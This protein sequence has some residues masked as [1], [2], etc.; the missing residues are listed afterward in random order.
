MKRIFGLTLVFILFACQPQNAGII[1]NILDGDNIISLQTDSN[2]PA[3]ILV[4]A[5]VVLS[6]VDKIQ[7]HGADLPADFSLPPGGAYTLQIRRANTLTLITPD[8]HLT[9][10]TAAAN[11]GQA[12]AQTGLKLF[13]AD[14]VAPALETPVN[15][16]F[17][18]TYRPARDLTVSTDGKTIA[19][20]SSQQTIGQALASAGFA[21][22]GLD[23]SL[24]GE[25][26]PLPPDGQIKIM[27][28]SETV[29]LQEKAIPFSKKYEYSVD[30]PVGEQKVLQV[31]ELGLTISRIRIRYEDGAEVGRI[32]EAEIVVL[33][34]RESIISLSTQIQI[35]TLNTP[36]GQIQYW[37]AVQMYTT[38]Y[39]PCGSGTPKCSYGTASGLPVKHGVVALIPSLY[40]QLAGSQVYIPGYGVGVIGDV[41]G[42]FP[43]GRL[44]IDLGYSDGDY[45]NWSGFH[46]VYFLAPAPVRIPAGLN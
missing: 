7:F 46:T 30:Q 8:G 31:G 29:T 39:S 18:V 2:I 37:R 35:Q 16:D 34:P 15:T 33:Q 40:N 44:W 32:T 6:A 4:Q 3:A 42:G 21:L 12:L 23:K 19:L 38:S 24:P 5:G 41:G 9:I 25:S 14:F 43:D 28:I 45:Q 10:K 27:R 20:K 13:A 22:I 26:E 1:V 17:T 11:V 36:D